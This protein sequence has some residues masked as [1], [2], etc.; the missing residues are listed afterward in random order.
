MSHSNMQNKSPDLYANRQLEAFLV[1]SK[2]CHYANLKEKKK[3]ETG[4]LV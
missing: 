4:N 1:N 3:G 2:R